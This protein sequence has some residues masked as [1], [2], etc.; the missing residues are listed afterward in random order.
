MENNML[1]KFG[2]ISIAVIAIISLAALLFCNISVFARIIERPA[3]WSDELLRAVF[4]WL[5]YLS[6]PFACI[7]NKLIGITLLE[8]SLLKKKNKL[9][10]RLVKS[11]QDLIMLAVALLLGYQSFLTM[12]QQFAGNETSAV[13]RFP[14]GLITM[15]FALGNICWVL[16]TAY[17]LIT[18]WRTS[19]AALSDE[20][21]SEADEA[22]QKFNTQEAS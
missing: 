11:F 4:V 19:D 8:E 21:V 6:I 18:L 17:K 1:K 22:L 15:G 20:L 2:N 14:T 9:W 7:E 10:Y 5:F 16:C 12:L 13:L 3:P